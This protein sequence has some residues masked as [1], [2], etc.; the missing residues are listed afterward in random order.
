MYEALEASAAGRSG[1]DAWL[2]PHSG[3]RERIATVHAA[4]PHGFVRVGNTAD[5]SNDPHGF[6]MALAELALK[7]YRTLRRAKLKLQTALFWM[8]LGRAAAAAHRTSRVYSS[9][10]ETKDD[11]H[12]QIIAH[13]CSRTDQTASGHPGSFFDWF[14]RPVANSSDQQKAGAPVSGRHTSELSHRGVA[15][16]AQPSLAAREEVGDEYTA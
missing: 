16:S 10:A 2:P 7:R 3:L 5:A 14:A 8:K 15:L 12:E 1:L 11:G 9:P 13:T 6:D 4:H